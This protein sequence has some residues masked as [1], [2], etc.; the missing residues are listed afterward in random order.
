[1]ARTALCERAGASLPIVTPLRYVGTAGW[2]IPSI[3]R[4]RFP[5][6]GSQLQRY[7]ARL[8]AA[9]INTSFYRPHAITTYERWAAVVP[10]SFRFAIKVPR[11]YA[12]SRVRSRPRSADAVSR[13]DFRPRRKDRS[14]ARAAAA[15]IRIRRS[16]R[17][18]LLRVAAEAPRR[19]GRVRASTRDVDGCGGDEAAGVVPHRSRRC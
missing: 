16:T 8:N 7:A 6:G 17:R 11:H 4:S 10:R 18:P 2:N 19:R 12:R 14:A 13:G 9:E 3:H 1:R 5:S 15:V